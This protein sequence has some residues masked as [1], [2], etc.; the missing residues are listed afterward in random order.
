MLAKRAKRDGKHDG[1]ETAN[2]PTTSEGMVP[3]CR[4]TVFS[5]AQVLTPGITE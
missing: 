1:H 3:G 4:K 2:M 5:L